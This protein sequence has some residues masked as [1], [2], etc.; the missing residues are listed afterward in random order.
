MRQILQIVSKICENVFLAR[1]LLSSAR[2]K[3]RIFHLL[4][5]RMWRLGLLYL[6][7]FLTES[8]L[9]QVHATGNKDKRLSILQ[10]LSKIKFA[11]Y[12]VVRVFLYIRQTSTLFN[13]IVNCKISLGCLTC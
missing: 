9:K 7:F 6:L 13:K 8:N 4:K 12:S 10:R 3:I 1:F 5:D 11:I 2:I